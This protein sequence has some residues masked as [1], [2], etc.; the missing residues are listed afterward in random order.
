V[1][2]Y[3]KN[4]RL[5]VQCDE[6]DE[7][8]HHQ[9]TTVAL[10]ISYVHPTC[11]Y[12]RQTLN[13]QPLHMIS[14]LSKWTN[15]IFLHFTPINMIHFYKTYYVV[16]ELCNRWEEP[17]LPFIME[18]T[19]SPTVLTLVIA[20]LAGKCWCA[21]GQLYFL[22]CSIHGEATALEEK[23]MTQCYRIKHKH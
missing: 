12:A 4:M 1:Y 14:C 9:H 18:E 13:L 11:N 2:K 3:V 5:H 16:W 7:C 15:K 17:Q 6:P 22:P 21:K 19:V 23:Y 20:T 10:I 8:N